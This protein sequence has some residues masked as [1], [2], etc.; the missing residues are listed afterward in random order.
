MGLLEP[1]YHAVVLRQ[2]AAATF[3]GEPQRA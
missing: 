3:D 2:A 1:A